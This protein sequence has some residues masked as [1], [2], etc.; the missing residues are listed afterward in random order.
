MLPNP[1]S[2]T[3]NGA[4]SRFPKVRVDGSNVLLRLDPKAFSSLEFMVRKGLAAIRNGLEIGGLV[5]GNLE[6][7]RGESVVTVRR[8]IP[9]E[10]DY[11]FGI[12]FRPSVNE[13]QEFAK[14]LSEVTGPDAEVIGCFRSHLGEPIQ[15]REEDC[16]LL[17]GLF[18]GRECYLI[19]VQAA[20]SEASVAYCYARTNKRELR[21]FH[22][23]AVAEVAAEEPGKGVAPTIDALASAGPSG[24]PPVAGPALSPTPGQGNTRRWNRRWFDTLG[25]LA[26]A[27]AVFASGRLS[28]STRTRPANPVPMA[29]SDDLAVVGLSVRSEGRK[30]EVTW[31]RTSE[32][33]QKAISGSLL[34]SDGTAGDR[35]EL[36]AAQVRAGIY[37][38]SPVQSDL[39]FVLTLYQ[40]NES[41]A[42]QA[43]YFHANL[44][45]K[46]PA[47]PRVGRNA[48][49]ELRMEVRLAGRRSGR[50]PE[51]KQQATAARDSRPTAG[52]ENARAQAGQRH[53]NAPTPDMEAPPDL[54]TS[55]QATQISIPTLPAPFS[56]AEA[57][58]SP[59]TPKALTFSAPVPLKRVM[60]AIAPSTR[61]LIRDEVSV[62][63]AINVDPQGKVTDAHSVQ[64]ES[65]VA[66]MLAA[67]AVQAAKLWQFE[68][69]RR[70]GAPVAGEA[71]VVFH[72]TR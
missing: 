54:G 2:F 17:Q 44:P 31:N 21:L 58:K 20:A 13:H 8:F 36:N 41:F 29:H 22:K 15:V 33:V 65:G 71:V 47:P 7:A 25:A 27:V 34:I 37:E 28:V 3:G 18:G 40:R 38:Y 11:R 6:V 66:R 4:K 60:P 24:L 19:L 14:V 63:V 32:A 69:A 43:Q 10:V 64:A 35:V 16:A 23:F 61:S 1:Q 45:V 30:V 55:T 67:P 59:D 5:T 39:S 56:S 50:V 12:R 46:T 57:G 70:D 26:L 49:R 53:A 9:V 42:G 52:L 72:F 62:R 68:P 48:T 51:I